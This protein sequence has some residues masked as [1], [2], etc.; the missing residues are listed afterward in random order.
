MS[1][2]FLTF[3]Q[4]HGIQRDPRGAFE[5]ILD[6]PGSAPEPEQ[7]ARARAVPAERAAVSEPAALAEAP[8][9]PVAPSPARA[10]ARAEPVAVAPAPQRE[11]PTP[12]PFRIAKSFQNAASTAAKDP[13]F[14]KAMQPR[15]QQMRDEAAGIHA[16]N[17]Q[18]DPMADP[19]GYAQHMGTLD[20]HFGKPMGAKEVAYWQKWQAG[21]KAERIARA[22]EALQKGDLATLKDNID[23]LL[24]EGVTAVDIQTGK[25][26][27][28]GVE[29]PSHVIMLQGP[30][31]KPLPP[32]NSVE[33]LA[34]RASLETR[35]NLAK[36]QQQADDA[37]RKAPTMRMQEENIALEVQQKNKQLKQDPETLA[38]Q[39]V[40]QDYYTWSGEMLKS[41]KGNPEALQ[42]VKLVIAERAAQLGITL[43]SASPESHLW[44]NNPPPGTTGT[45]SRAQAE[46]AAQQAMLEAMPPSQRIQYAQQQEQQRI[47]DKAAS[48][49]QQ[50]LLDKE[51]AAIASQAAEIQRDPAAKQQALSRLDAIA[52]QYP[53][54]RRAAEAV[55][56]RLLNPAP[57]PG[58]P[59]WYVP[60]PSAS[61][62]G[63]GS[64][65]MP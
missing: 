19:A 25:A 36:A 18:G 57:I 20:A 6:L 12:D 16:A 42:A 2:D 63:P 1:I 45:P 26:T 51:L 23:D 30:D 9:E 3:L 43:P 39:K 53:A 46:Q 56:K 7:V 10:V 28:G 31:G 24:G 47:R 40:V 13:E 22:E 50:Q 27:I 29:V 34:Q 32:I 55:I 17:F 38:R 14:F 49:Q 54:M 33:W 59:A 21:D 11:P 64:P 8:V 41:A 58:P 52:E 48:Q 15:L 62:P 4:Q 61:S 65:F 44:G 37:K 35:V 60:T 5:E